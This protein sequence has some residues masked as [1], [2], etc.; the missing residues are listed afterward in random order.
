M[1]KSANNER[2]NR[3]RPNEKNENE[4][5]RDLPGYPHYPASEDILDPNNGF[6]KTGTD[7]EDLANSTRLSSLAAG[8]GQEPETTEGRTDEDDDDVKIVPGTE[9][10][11]TPEDL[12]LLGDRDED[13]DM[14]DDELMHGN[15]RVDDRDLQGDLLQE[16]ELDIPDATDEKDSLGQ[17]DEEND[18]YSLGGDTKEGLEEDSQDAE[19]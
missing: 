14:Q 5:D 12:V 15:A 3:N 10:D 16:D 8:R 2:T 17:G 13:M 19:Q 6:V 1:S 7:V 4:S 9:A 18:Y 11:V